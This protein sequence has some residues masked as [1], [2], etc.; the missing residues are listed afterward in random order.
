MYLMYVDESGDCGLVNSP[1]QFFVLTGFVLHDSDWRDYLDSLLTFRRDLRNRYGLKVREEI[2]AGPLLTHPGSLS[3]IHKSDRLAIL[4]GFADHVAGLTNARIIN[5]V[6]DKSGKASGYDVFENAWQALIQRFENTISHRNF[7]GAGVAPEFGLIIP[8]H[9]DDKKIK[10][11]LRRSR[12]FNPIPNQ[13]WAGVGSRNL[14]LSSIIEDPAFRDSRE[15]YF[16]QAAD[17][18][19]FLLYQHIAPS[20]Y[21]KKK[22]GHN[23]FHRLRRVLCSQ[24]ARNDPDGIV[25]L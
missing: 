19:A 21:M 4:R 16:I 13:P 2:H 10:A 5:V 20:G 22:S 7:P 3:R 15:S 12:R 11:L 6:V 25:R 14:P 24:A 18:A 8:D 1:T 9:S 23:Y 17:L